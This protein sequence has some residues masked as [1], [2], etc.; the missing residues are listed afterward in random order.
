MQEY[1]WL[2]GSDYR[3]MIGAIG[4]QASSRKLGLTACAL[5]RRVWTTFNDPRPRIAIETAEDY[6]DFQA[7]KPQV[8]A[9]KQSLHAFIEDTRVQWLQDKANVPEWAWTDPEY[10]EWWGVSPPSGIPESVGLIQLVLKPSRVNIDTLLAVAQSFE[11]TRVDQRH[12]CEL[13]RDIFGNPFRPAPFSPDWRTDTA[14]ALARV[15]YES[16]EFS[17]MPILADALQ[18]AGCD[19]ESILAHCRDT[20]QAH[21]RGCWVV[22]LLLGKE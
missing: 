14:A 17:A 1:A 21:V 20:N 6:A 3:G 10:A 12:L 5:V 8:K 15:M 22:D 18:D 9:A 11:I 13:L 2:H 4:K 7:T 16:R 19:N